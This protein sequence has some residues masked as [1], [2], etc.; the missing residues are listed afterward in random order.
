MRQ[1]AIRQKQVQVEEVPEPS[2]EAGRVLVD[3]RA[4]A[5][6]TGTERA[7]VS[8]GTASLASRALR[9]PQ[10]VKRVFAVARERGVRDATAKVRQAGDSAKP[11]GYSNAGVVVDTGGAPDLVVGQRVACAGAGYAAHAD[12]VSVPAQLVVPV[13]DAVPFEHAAFTTIG[14]IAMNGI[15]RAELTLGE[16]VVV[17]GLGLIGQVCV[18]LAARSGARVI[19]S[20]PLAERRELAA[21]SGAERVAAPEELEALVGALT[22]EGADAAIIAAHAPGLRLIDDAVA[23]LRSKGRVVPLGAMP[24]EVDR[25]PLYQREADVLIATS[26]G[27]G[28]YDRAYEEH[29]IDY[30]LAWVRWTE[31]RNMEEVLR[32][33]AAGDL[34][35]EPMIERTVPITD[36]ASLYEGE[37]PLAAV[38]RYDERSARSAAPAAPPMPK[39]S[40]IEL[41]LIGP[42]GFAQAFLVPPLRSDSRAT[43]RWVVARTP[44]S[45]KRLAGQYEARAETDYREALADDAVD[46]VFVTTRHDSHAEIAAAALEAGKAVYC[47]KPLGL[48]H[49]EIDQVWRAAQDNPRLVIGFNRRRAP[50]VEQMVAALAS[51]EGPV[52]MVYRVN[53]PLPKDAFLNDP[54]EGGGRLLGEGCHFADLSNFVCG[55]PVRV[56]GHAAPARPGV[57]RP[58]DLTFS[59]SYADGSIATVIYTGAGTKDLPKERIEVFR[60]GAALVLDD[61]KRLSG[62]GAAGGLEASSETDKGHAANVAAFL[63]AA[64]GEGAFEPGI[65]AAYLAQEVVLAAQDSIASG[66]SI[67]IEGAPS[68]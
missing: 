45:A 62:Y 31:R 1:V 64:C 67:P 13:P 5:V 47:E 40:G 14:A 21:A 43:I 33:M 41:A 18:Q 12:V 11:L 9:N 38:I 61:F 28:R 63:D 54:I 37:A 68:R 4:S 65:E 52:T 27:P 35:L 58:E 16:T 60:G 36:A 3:V 25:A 55:R 48:S 53:S 66:A 39:R 51:L 23:L 32:L 57:A 19:A 8:G 30:P 20:D 22:E 59:I 10:L 42:G 6:S 17:M 29:G 2:P 34:D 44:A 15:R 46:A 24:I 56:T 26:Y 49:D 50:L 7:S